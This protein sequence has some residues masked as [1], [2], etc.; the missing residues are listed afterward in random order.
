MTIFHSI[1]LGLVEGLTEFLPISSTFHL[2]L[3]S[4][5]LGLPATDFQK[6][7]EVFIQS[8]AIL[9]VFILFFKRLTTDKALLV[10][11]FFSFL[12][13]ALI[14][15]ALR[16]VIKNTF[17][18]AEFLQYFVFL[19][20]GLIF[21]LIQHKQSPDKPIS[22][23]QALIIGLIQAFAV[24]P[25]V[26]RSGSVLIAMAILGFNLKQSAQYSF[27]LA[28]PVL[29]AAGSLDLWQSRS[30]LQ[31]NNLMLLFFGFLAAFVSALFVVRWFMNFNRTHGLKLWGIYR[32][33]LGL[34]LILSAILLPKV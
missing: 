26:S 33:I 3:T 27:L 19:A 31:A 11:L 12:P 10:N 7:F 24:I 17:F 18:Q 30:L 5:L 4:R 28:I 32:L 14:A 8:G 21:L 1:L 25:G 15:F 16:H 22:I 2:I 6:L 29:L 23:K 20:V 34:I 9:A 13:T